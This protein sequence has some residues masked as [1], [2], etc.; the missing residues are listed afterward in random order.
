MQSEGR[1]L[2]LYR[3][4]VGFLEGAGLG[5]RLEAVEGGAADFVDIRKSLGT[6]EG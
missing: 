1:D 2:S 4:E 3:Q 5:G 6:T